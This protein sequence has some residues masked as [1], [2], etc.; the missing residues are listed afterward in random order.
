MSNR[1]R[2]FTVD[3]ALAKLLEEEDDDFFGSGS[4][5][6]GEHDP[7]GR[8]DNWRHPSRP[9]NSSGDCGDQSSGDEETTFS[10]MKSTWSVLRR[11][12]LALTKAADA[13]IM[14]QIAT[15]VM[16]KAKEE[17]NGPCKQA[18]SPPGTNAGA[19]KIVWHSLTPAILSRCECL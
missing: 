15:K 1:R 12:H 4:D 8:R 2:L 5:S 16:N 13:V 17:C 3:E 9:S 18:V 14:R 6:E 7:A 19:K 11:P 10:T